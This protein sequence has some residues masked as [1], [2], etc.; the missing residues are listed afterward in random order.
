MDSH[1][2]LGPLCYLGF[3]S[4]TIFMDKH[5]LT[6]FLC[7]FVALL[8]IASCQDNLPAA[9]KEDNVS[10]ASLYGTLGGIP[11]WVEQSIIPGECLSGTT[12]SY[13]DNYFKDYSLWTIGGLSDMAYIDP[14]ILPTAFDYE[15]KALCLFLEMPLSVNK[16]QMEHYLYRNVPT[17]DILSVF[18]NNAEVIKAKYNDMYRAF[19][20]GKELYRYQYTTILYRHNTLSLTANVP[21]LGIPAGEDL[22]S[23]VYVGCFRPQDLLSVP[24]IEYG[25]NEIALGSRFQIIIPAN[26]PSML[27]QTVVFNLSMPVKV[28]MYL[29]WLNDRISNPDAEMQYQDETLTCKFT[30][31]KG[32]R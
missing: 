10:Y 3:T 26:N 19:D 6:S 25:E 27:A 30:I 24:G 18:G 31:Y 7:L 16:E 17:D 15:S 22:G 12:L 4:K 23:E 14:S 2:F 1:S 21:F 28:G 11:Q 29:H 20:F 9:E 5:F 32:L 13:N 8:S